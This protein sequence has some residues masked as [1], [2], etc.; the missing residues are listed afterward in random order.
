M[1]LLGIIVTE[2]VRPKPINWRPSYTATSKIPFGCFVLFNELP[3]LFPNSKIE[4]VEESVYDVLIKRDSNHAS[5]Y[6]IINDF[7]ALDQQ[8]VNQL[9]NFVAS[10]NQVFLAASELGGPL[11]DT[12][13]IRIERHYGF[14]EDSVTVDL[15]HHSF[16]SD[17]FIFERGVYPA[18]FASIDTIHTEILGHMKFKDNSFLNN[19]E[20]TVKK[21]PNFIKTNFGE[22]SFLINTLP[23]AFTNYYVLTDNQ[24]YVTQTFSYLKDGHLYWDNY[25]KSGRI[26]I[27]SP[28]RFVLN[29]PALKWAYYLAIVGLLLFVVF[30]SKREQR[31]IPIL[32]PLEN[33]SVEFTRTVGSLYHQNKDYTDLNGKKINFFLSFVRRNYYMNTTVL[34]ENFITQLSVKSGNHLKE[35]KQLIEFII[36]LKNKPFHSEN[37]TITLSKKINT[38]TQSHGR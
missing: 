8:E 34:D 20:R 17:S 28:M 11:A 12:L 35:T 14:S 25:K 27:T 3:T 37:D 13:N 22:G 4:T 36:G 29:Q 21:V 16:K 6:L 32:K 9:L 33:S 24:K 2:I 30:K 23:V 1:V 7:L 38:F 15:T 31:I 19:E 10:G 18:Y 5:S 26:I